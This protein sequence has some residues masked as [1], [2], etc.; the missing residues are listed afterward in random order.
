MRVTHR[1]DTKLRE[2]YRSKLR[3]VAW[4]PGLVGEELEQLVQLNAASLDR[5]AQTLVSKRRY[6]VA[7]PIPDT[8]SAV[9]NAHEL[10]R[11]Y[12]SRNWPVGHRRH[13]EDARDY[14]RLRQRNH[15]AKPKPQELRS[16]CRN[17]QP[18][19]AGATATLVYFTT[20]FVPSRTLSVRLAT[21]VMYL[22]G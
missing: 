11:Y 10:F 13:Q 22:L 15:L 7:H 2:Q 17:C 4:Q 14:Q 1:R 12:T 20:L 9:D 5:R 19:I 3:K 16:L 18:S 6:E 8:I 21:R